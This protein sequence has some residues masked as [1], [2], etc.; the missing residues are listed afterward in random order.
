MRL[1]TVLL[2]SYALLALTGCTQPVASKTTK[3]APKPSTTDTAKPE[4]PPAPSAANKPAD[5]P[6]EKPA[7]KPG[8]KAAPPAP[9][10]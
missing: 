8:D 10:K 9:P 3:V 6:A 1:L 2:I 7:D 4:T 5:K